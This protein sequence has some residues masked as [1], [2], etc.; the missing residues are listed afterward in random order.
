MSQRRRRRVEVVIGERV[1][2]LREERAL[3]QA[4]LA[5]LAGTSQ[6]SLAR[7]EAGERSATLGSLVKIADALRLTL[8]ELLTEGVP[9]APTPKS[10]KMWFRISARL[11]DRDADFLRGVEHLIR[12]L[13]STQR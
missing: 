10:E 13:E 8:A 3:T 5:R 4:A 11:R 12:A 9:A 2:A 7:I 1:R 6:S